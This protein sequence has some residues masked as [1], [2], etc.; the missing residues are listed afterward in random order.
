MHEILDTVKKPAIFVLYFLFTYLCLAAQ[1]ERLYTVNGELPS[2]MI[3]VIAQDSIGNIWIG[4]EDGLCRYDGAKFAKY[5]HRS[6]DDE[7]LISNSITALHVTPEGTLYVGSHKGLQSYDA[8]YDRFENIPLV[9][10]ENDTTEMHVSSMFS[11]PDGD[12]ILGTLG[13]GVMRVDK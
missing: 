3:A 1:T 10:E 4:T 5:T 9:L 8:D 2:S 11:L 12:I 13:H 6:D 7:S